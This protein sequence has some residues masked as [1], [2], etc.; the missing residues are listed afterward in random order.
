MKN[1]KVVSR[2][3]DTRQAPPLT[4][5]EIESMLKGNRFARI[6]THNQDGTIHATPVS[7]RYTNGQI[8]IL[9]NI[10][11]QKVRN[12]ER[13]NDVTV[14]VDEVNTLRGIQ[15]HGKAEIEYDN[16]DEK[17]PTVLQTAAPLSGVPKE[18][19]ERVAKAYVDTFKLVILRIT[20][21]HIESFD[22]GKYEAWSNWGKTLSSIIGGRKA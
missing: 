18:K 5:E 16:V 3:S 10:K 22:Y 8:L 11:S 14:L 6:C 4:S 15:I 20:P 9:T 7:Y 13:N 21:K 19:L 1:C 2:L 12:I 17:A